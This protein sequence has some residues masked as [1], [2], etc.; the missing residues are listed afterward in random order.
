MRF[1]SMCVGVVV[2]LWIAVVAAA[3]FQG[4]IAIGMISNSIIKFY[5][6]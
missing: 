2:W 3:I 6:S 1:L 5:L 4:S